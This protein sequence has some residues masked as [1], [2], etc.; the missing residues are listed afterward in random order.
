M[1]EENNTFDV[2]I[3]D[4]NLVD[5]PAGVILAIDDHVSNLRIIFD[6]LNIHG[7]KTIIATSGEDGIRTARLARPDLILLDVMMSG[8]DGYETCR[9]L[10]ADEATQDI[11]VI[12]M[13]V[14]D[15]VEH[16]VRAFEAGGVDYITKPLRAEEMLAR[17]KTHLTLRHLQNRLESHNEQ[18]EALVAARTTDL[19]AEV[20][21]RKKSEQD[22][23]KLLVVAGQQS[24]QLQLMTTLLLESYQQKRQRLSQTLDEQIKAQLGVVDRNLE[25]I[26]SILA[27]INPPLPGQAG[28]AAGY[29]RDS[30][31]MVK[32]IITEVNR[33]TSDLLG[34]LPE[35]SEAEVSLTSRE[36]QVLQ[37]LADGKSVTSIA[38]MLKISPPTVYGHRRSLMAK[39]GVDNLA[40]ML[41]AAIEQGLLP[42]M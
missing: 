28:L 5:T 32:A 7:Y 31:S 40:D 11:P 35:E 25:M 29:A 39:L 36:W 15:E 6:Y 37:M 13:T 34:A 10:K 8:V 22:K 9:Q 21:Q 14:L 17:V 19:R 24:E 42:A 30:L 2:G 12:F 16:K 41:R 20:E 33:V 4:D 1:D 23:D 27:D 3:R 26:C 18:L 38:A